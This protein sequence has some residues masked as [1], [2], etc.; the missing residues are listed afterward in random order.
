[1]S[2]EELKKQIGTLP[3]RQQDEI[4]AYLFHLRHADDVAFQSDLNRR[5]NDKDPSHWL[6]PDQFE[7]ELDRRNPAK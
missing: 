5:L 4:V 6:T 2:V 7:Q 1:M 3:R